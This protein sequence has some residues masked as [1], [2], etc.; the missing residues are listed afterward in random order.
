MTAP[1]RVLIV[2]PHFPPARLGGT[3]LRA[4]K[5]SK[6]LA[7]H[8]INAQVL[9]VESLAAAPDETCSLTSG[10]YQ[11]IKVHRLDLTT[12]RTPRGFQFSFDS[13]LVEGVIDKLIQAEEIDLIHLISGYLV[14]ACAVRAAHRHNLPIVVTLTD[15]WFLCPR[16]QLIRSTG[17]I[18]DGPYS[19]L[20]CARCLLSESRRFRWPEKV[21]P[22]AANLAWRVL[23]RLV[24]L[25]SRLGLY[26][27]ISQ[28]SSILIDLLNKADAVTVPTNS[29][30]PRLVRAGAADRFILSRHSLDF[31]QVEYGKALPKSASSAIRFGYIGQIQYSKGIDLVIGAF[32]TL[33]KR[34]GNITLDIWGQ[35]PSTGFG[36]RVRSMCRD[37]ENVRLCGRYEP[38]D[39]PT[40][41]AGIDVLIV[42]SRWPEIGPF[43]I[44]EAFATRTPV[45]AANIGNIPELVRHDVDGLLFNAGDVV[46]LERQMER[47]VADGSLYQRLVRGIAGVRTMNEEMAEILQVYESAIAD[48]KAICDSV[49]A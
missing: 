24:P 43:V 9:C 20:D 38:S 4:R 10:L 21:M 19:A 37:L 18:C 25:R 22:A 44:L 2:T 45:I 30:R 48:R 49:S 36:A 12:S 26:R 6:G 1:S 7:Q 47:I 16:I 3:E 41:M 29:L 32:R 5:L 35:P 23:D 15:Y 8:G 28:R 33:S 40:V 31:E 14:T 13:P 11:G 27:L 46:D 17:D 39:L 34:Y 42:P